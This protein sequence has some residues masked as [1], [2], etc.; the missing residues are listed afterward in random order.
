MSDWTPAT[1]RLVELLGRTAR[2][3]RRE[4]VYALWLWCARP[5]K[6]SSIHRSGRSSGAVTSKHSGIA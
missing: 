1:T 3:P 4:G 5:R 2:G 6:D